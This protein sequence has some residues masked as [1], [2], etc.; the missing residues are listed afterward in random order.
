MEMPACFSLPLSKRLGLGLELALENVQPRIREPAEELLVAS[1]YLFFFFISVSLSLLFTRLVRNYAVERGW[2]VTP[3]LD[4]HV[5]K[6][7]V[8]RVGGVAIFAAF[9]AVVGLASLLPKSIGFLPTRTLLTIFASGTI[10]FLLGLYD[11][12]YL[13]GPYLKFGVQALAAFIL[14][15]GGVGVHRVD[16]F[17]PDH[18]L[19]ASLGLPL[20]VVWIL[21]ITNAFN[22][23]DG[24]DGLAAGSACFSTLVVF[25]TSLFVPNATVTLL[26]IV[27]AGV[28]LGFL[29]FN[30]YPASIFMGDSGS[31]FIGFMLAALALAGSEKAPTMLA[32]AIPVIAFGFPIM[33]VALA[34]SRRLVSGKHL[35]AGDRDHIHHKLLDRGLSQ[36][37]AVLVLYAVTAGFALLSLVVL[38]DAAMLALVLMIIFIG[39]S[40]GVPY[41]GYAELSEVQGFVRRTVERRRSMSH[42]VQLRHAVQAMNSCTDV[43]LLCKILKDALQVTG[44][45][46]FRLRIPLGKDFVD[47]PLAPLER[48][49]C[50]HLQSLWAETAGCPDPA[51]MA[52]INRG[53]RVEKGSLNRNSSAEKDN[54][55]LEKDRDEADSKE[56]R[57]LESAW[58]LRLA[59]ATDDHRIFGYCELLRLTGD[60]PL[61]VDFNFLTREFRTALAIAVLRSVRRN[62]TPGLLRAPSTARNIVKVVSAG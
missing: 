13:V 33:D 10:I 16:L 62:P 6:T 54:K 2:V 52:V 18:V 43:N 55:I 17:S 31:M 21:L 44:F 12:L 47:A 40:L 20:T 7:S 45:D 35:F 56:I 51:H 34:V 14:Y 38:H 23:I 48:T 15:S 36:R 11:D 39:L 5:H 61:L 27:L 3:Q 28:T 60:S 37:N 58:E 25:V 19:R 24:L 30:F 26:A 22:L 53:R 29:R 9:M 59:L 8:P 4:R 32:V 42:T 1:A 46:G 57:D 49:A 50:G 41:L